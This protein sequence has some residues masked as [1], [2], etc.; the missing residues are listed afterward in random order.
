[1]TNKADKSFKFIQI[2]DWLDVLAISAWGVLLLQYWLTGKLG[3]LVHPNYFWLIIASGFA[4][5]LIAA[6]RTR[7]LWQK[8]PKPKI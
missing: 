2:L 1:M 5:L 8:H 7:G 6:F 4:L 3:L